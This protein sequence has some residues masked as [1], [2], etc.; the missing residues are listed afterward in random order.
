MFFIMDDIEKE[1]N[2]FIENNRD[3]IVSSEEIDSINSSREPHDH[4]GLDFVDVYW[5]NSNSDDQFILDPT[6]SDSDNYIL[7]SL[8]SCFGDDKSHRNIVSRAGIVK[9]VLPDIAHLVPDAIRENEDVTYNENVFSSDY[10]PRKH[11][12]VIPIMGAVE[13]G[14]DLEIDY[15][16]GA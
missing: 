5:A 13:Y 1:Y 11:R 12:T 3:A 9:K 7:S 15:N 8:E 10:K 2:T 6:G 14:S 16:W 4:W